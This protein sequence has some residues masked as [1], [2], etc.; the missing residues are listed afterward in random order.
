MR[1]TLPKMG[2]GT[3]IVVVD[4]T[5]GDNK[6]S[7]VLGFLGYMVACGMFKEVLVHHHLV[8]HSH[9]DVDA[10]IGVLAK[11]IRNRSIDT[12]PDFMS[13]CQDAVKRK[14]G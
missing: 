2:Q 4:N 9:I 8:G 13:H 12:L 6:N 11:H 5:S 3:L 14:G 7:F 10:L 1:E